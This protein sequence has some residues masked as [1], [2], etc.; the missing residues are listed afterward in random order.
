[1]CRMRIFDISSSIMFMP[2]GIPETYIR[3]Y[4][5]ERMLFGSDFP[6]WDPQQEVQG[7]LNLKL[8]PAEQE[9]IAHKTAENLLGI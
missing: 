1:M 3:R 9:Q 8:T 7:F 2:E 4:G 5:A 6:L